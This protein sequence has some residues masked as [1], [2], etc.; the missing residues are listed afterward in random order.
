MR[1]L[2]F[3][4]R[5]VVAAAIAA[6]SLVAAAGC[7]V[8]DE[9]LSPQQPGVIGPDNVQGAVGAE[10]L[11]LG[12]LSAF[13]GATGGNSAT[14]MWSSA[15]TLADEWKSGDTFFQTDETDRRTITTTNSQVQSQYT[16]AQQ[17][18]GFI[19]AAIAAI[20]Q[21]SP[22][23]AENMAEMYLT[24]GFLEMNL[25]ENFCNG[26]P[27][28]STVDG[29][30]VYVASSTNKQG[31]TLALA[32][33]DSGL[34]LL[35][36]VAASNVFGTQV[37]NGLL[38][39][40]A[41]ALVDLDRA[42]LTQAAALVTAVPTTFAWNLTYSTS[43]AD[44]GPWSMNGIAAS[45]RYVVS[46]SFDFF[47]GQL[48]V[49][50]NALPF[51]SA[52]DPRV[53]TTGATT[54]TIRAIDAYTP[55]VGQLIWAGRSDPVPVVSGIDARLIEAE[56]KLNAGDIAGMMTTLNALRTAP[57][58]IG[59]LKV[60]AMSTLATPATTDAAVSLLFREAGFWQFGR[61]IRL[62]SLRR[63]IR[64]YA[65]TQD[66]VFPVGSYYKSGTYGT[67]VNLPVTDNEYTNPNFHGCIDRNA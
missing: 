56:A 5:S 11:R 18:R 59:N 29:A 39:T 20:R 40:K 57:Q 61:G 36:S 3:R 8:K 65:R 24:L 55:W 51:G 25:S 52:K 10:A 58:Q 32:R 4:A 7:N 14:S 1:H 31:F 37:K 33:L 62:G 50:K 47:N 64:Q 63:L 26:I 67:D 48:N 44:N 28:G 16:A 60:A 35:P 34:A 6:A 21:Y 15:G 38:V 43:S 66:Q 2:T 30:P 46:D 42:N 12:A 17:A 53:P 27:Y 22:E 19:S 54:G 49:V 9:L 13:Q 41:R 45:S 23:K